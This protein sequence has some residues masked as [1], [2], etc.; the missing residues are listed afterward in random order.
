M[1]DTTTTKASKEKPPRVK[2]KPRP[3]KTTASN[4][5]NNTRPPSRMLT[6]TPS[7]STPD[8]VV[9]ED[10]DRNTD[11][12][13]KRNQSD[14]ALAEGSHPKPK[15]EATTVVKRPQGGSK[16]KSGRGRRYGPGISGSQ[17]ARGS[18]PPHFGNV[19]HSRAALGD[20][21]IHVPPFFAS[22]HTV[23]SLLCAVE[24]MVMPSCDFGAAKQVYNR[25]RNEKSNPY[26]TSLENG[27]RIWNAANSL[28]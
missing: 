9:G 7:Y 27:K 23:L 24:P 26:D 20:A 11:Y 8:L 6:A 3:K 19:L 16:G 4:S 25:A 28:L 10:E 1:G 21:H 13:I 2:A 14:A 15:P 17:T 5:I 22:S 18:T 12:S